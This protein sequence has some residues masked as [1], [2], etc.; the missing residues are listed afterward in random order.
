AQ[1]DPGIDGESPR[2]MLIKAQRRW[3]EFRDADCKAKY[4]VF[5]GGTIRN[6]VYLSC[7]RERTKQRIKELAPSEWQG[8]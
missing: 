3:L 6:V 5:A 4:Q 7:L 1:N 8:G 2:A